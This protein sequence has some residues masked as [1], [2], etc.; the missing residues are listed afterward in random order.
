MKPVK[1]SINVQK[2][3]DEDAWLESR[4]GKFTGTRLGSAISKRD[5]KPKKGYYEIIAERVALP[6][7][8]ENVMDRGKRLESDA[9]DRLI[10][11]T[12]IKFDKSLV[13][14]S[15]EDEP[16]IAY[17]PDAFKG[18][19]ASVEV[20][21]LNSAS[22]IEA[23]LTKKIP[24]DYEEQSIQPFVVN[25]ALQKLYFVFYDPRLPKEFFYFVVERK[26][27]KDKIAFYLAL[28]RQMLAEIRQI[29][30]E[31]TF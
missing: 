23:W 3:E 30:N 9:V 21:C 27:I 6:H 10:K 22:H 4:L 1:L 17:S 5:G 28:E 20:K 18:K 8:G 25:D 16:D 24:L 14:I 26:D 19:T 15:R 13:L 29:E 7:N 31:L 12:G 11:E 2:F